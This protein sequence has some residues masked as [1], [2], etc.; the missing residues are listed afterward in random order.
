M[1]ITKIYTRLIVIPFLLLAVSAF[2]QD[3]VVPEWRR[4]ARL[5]VSCEE[6][7]QF[8]SALY[9]SQT[10]L[11]VAQEEFG[12]VD[13]TV[14]KLWFYVG[15]Y[16][17]AM[18]DY[19]NAEPSLNNC[20]DVLFELVEYDH[21]YIGMAM[22]TLGYVLNEQGKFTDAEAL[23]KR[24]LEIAREKLP[25][26]HQD[27]ANILANLGVLN[28]KLDRLDD[29]KSLT[30]EALEIRKVALG[31]NS[32]EVGRSFSDLGDIALKEGNNEEAA[33]CFANAL[34]IL[35]AQ[36]TPDQRLIGSTMT[37]L[38]NLYLEL[39]ESNKADSIY[40]LALGKLET[41][42]D[43]EHNEIADLKYNIGLNRSNRGNYFEA[44]PYLEDALA[45]Y[46]KLFGDDNPRIAEAKTVLGNLWDKIGNVARCRQ[47]FEEALAIQGKV[48]GPDHFETSWGLN[49][50]GHYHLQYGDL[51]SAKMYF[52]RTYDVRRKVRGDDHQSLIVPLHNLGQVAY[53]Q[54]NYSL[55]GLTISNATEII[56]KVYG[57]SHLELAR[58]YLLQA[59][60]K[61]A[62]NQFDS[63]QVFYELASE[64]FLKAF[65]EEFPEYL[66][67]LEGLAAVK[68]VQNEAENA[69]ELML[70][71]TRARLSS[72]YDNV[73]FLTEEDALSFAAAAKD[74]AARLLTLYFSNEAELFKQKENVIAAILG[75][76]GVVGDEFRQRRETILQSD[77][78]A[79]A[80][81]Y[82]QW[83]S[84][85]SQ[86]SQL[87]FHPSKD[88]AGIAHVSVQLDSLGEIADGLESKLG[89]SA[90]GGLSL[91]WNDFSTNQ[92]NQK[93]PEDWSVIE[94]IKYKSDSSFSG[95]GRQRFA[96]IVIGTGGL[97]FIRDVG[98]AENIENTVQAFRNHCEGVG[99]TKRY[100]TQSETEQLSQIASMLYDL[101]VEPI[102]DSL[103]NA[104]VL[105][106][107]PDGGLNLIPFATLVDNDGNYLIEKCAIHYVSTSRDLLQE[108]T[109]FNSGSGLLAL[110]DPEFDCD[111]VSRNTNDNQD[112]SVNNLR[113]RNLWRTCTDLNDF[114]V[115]SL[116]GTRIEVE[117][118]AR[119]WKNNS[120]ESIT[121][122]LGGD[123]S[124]AE[125]SIQAKGKKVI[126]IASHG[127][128]LNQICS[129]TDTAGANS[130]RLSG[131]L[132]NPMFNSAILLSC[133]TVSDSL[134][135]S[136]LNPEGLLSAYEIAAMDLNGTQ[137][138]VLSACESGLG[139]V[140]QGEGV[141]GLRRAFQIAGAKT[142]V[143][144]LWA[145]DDKSTSETI[146]Q[147]Y[148]FDDMSIPLK[149]QGIQ[150]ERIKELKQSGFAVHP[151]LWGA[152]VATGDW[153]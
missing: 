98:P 41:V 146:T 33:K 112:V 17:Q 129:E 145:I 77:D 4:L 64:I 143:S 56:K 16:H 149:L 49:N 133:A 76:K 110:G 35:E 122:L 72:F 96:A 65:G 106:I 113:T 5:A 67:C 121:V 8:D 139:H 58:N 153:R 140:Y 142:V 135:H 25:E 102:R 50:L 46:E 99:K 24:A 130:G 141:F 92:I 47:M 127:I 30:L 54:N 2:A 1:L 82:E 152:F 74:A 81:K 97:V 109:K 144:S 38:G 59:T 62:E 70:K 57:K 71:A 120:S 27:I 128:F 108:P 136:Q 10:A 117:Q 51:D 48:Y 22:N 90:H 53:R 80:S 124:K 14:A 7:S 103:S 147:L 118:I 83:R 60:C 18:S 40:L 148:G 95:D 85:R 61:Y 119:N 19:E 55:A 126:H 39:G 116:P 138:V 21:P 86:L 6:K 75:T 45:S 134:Q 87:Y 34:S 131:A 63:A 111:A 107:A 52:L 13:T 89:R 3:E 28:Y 100:P 12:E 115:A 101:I 105:L 151:Y 132:T 20:L 84:V 43:S 32:V 125:F 23:Y 79:F 26:N 29:A 66:D 44:I 78:T 93:L 104:K 42:F 37:S 11:K 36:E 31:E 68:N 114:T 94:Y 137:L 73:G 88:S 15:Y 123:A 150:L 91:D 9:Y 69:M